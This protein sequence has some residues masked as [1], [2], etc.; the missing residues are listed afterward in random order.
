MSKVFFAPTNKKV[1]STN[2]G[3]SIA[4]TPTHTRPT[5]WILRTKYRTLLFSKL[6]PI[7]LHQRKRLNKVT[8]VHALSE[9]NG[10]DRHCPALEPGIT[11]AGVSTDRLLLYVLLLLL[12]Q[13]LHARSKVLCEFT[14]V[15]EL[16][17]LRGLLL[18][19]TCVL[20][21]KI[22]GYFQNS[23]LF[24]KLN[25]KIILDPLKMS[26]GGKFSN[27]FQKLTAKSHIVSAQVQ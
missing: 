10:G 19:R 26:F 6:N 11:E 5:A 27:E 24:R 12:L 23:P 4:P 22:S 14:W 18:Q 1:Y 16:V 3:S 25:P 20:K 8:Y 9:H 2:I 13:L 17:R 21:V 7:A 15:N